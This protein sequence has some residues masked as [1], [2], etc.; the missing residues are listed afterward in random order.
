MAIQEF[1][2]F[3]S[4]PRREKKKG[5]WE[6]AAAA[7]LFVVF[8]SSFPVTGLEETAVTLAGWELRCFGWYT[9]NINQPSSSLLIKHSRVRRNGAKHSI[10]E[11][12]R[13]HGDI[14]ENVCHRHFRILS[15]L[16]D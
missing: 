12:L 13:P 16:H 15:L 5:K 8:S 11:V 3:S 2:V 6:V 10:Q 1:I 4:R 14:V 7:G 9:T